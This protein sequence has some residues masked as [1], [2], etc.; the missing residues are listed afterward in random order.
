MTA[1]HPLRSLEVGRYVSVMDRLSQLLLMLFV[2]A[3]PSPLSAT[4]S[5]PRAVFAAHDAEGRLPHTSIRKLGAV[6]VRSASYSIYYLTFVNPISHHGQQRIAVIK[7]GIHFAGA[8]QC[9]LGRDEGRIVI[10]KDRLTVS[11]DGMTY[12][13][14]FNESGPTRNKYF[15]GEGSG[16]ENSI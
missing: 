5:A 15:C 6:R 12:V 13:I 10:G 16:W 3:A 14:R 2:A 1:F 11:I 7:N 9:T 4:T 8:Y